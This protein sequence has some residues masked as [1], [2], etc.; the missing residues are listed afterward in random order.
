MTTPISP[1][2]YTCQWD[3]CGKVF[4]NAADL[5]NHLLLIPTPG[6][7][8]MG[9]II[10]TGE[11]RGCVDVACISSVCMYIHCDFQVR[12]IIVTGRTVPEI[13]S[14][15]EGTYIKPTLYVTT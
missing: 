2:L 11:I 13:H 15:K 3:G 1:A 14:L 7:M 5:S 9:H 10:K 8:G 6:N 12:A 4:Q